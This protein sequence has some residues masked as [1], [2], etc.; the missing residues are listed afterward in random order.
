M[1][2]LISAE[3]WHKRIVERAH[4]DFAEHQL[5]EIG[6]GHWRISRPDDGHYW[7]DIVVM[8]NCAIAVWGDIAGC[9]FAYCSGE[10]TPEGVVAWMANAD[11]SY[12]GRQK[13]H[14]GMGGIG[15]EQYVDGVALYDLDRHLEDAAEGFGVS[16]YMQ[17]VDKPPIGERYTPI[18]EEA[19][20]AIL[21]GDPIEHAHA[22][23][24]DELREFD[25]DCWE[26]VPSIGRVTSVRVIYAL[27]AI[28]RLWELLRVGKTEA[29]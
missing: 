17:D 19:K 23:L 8:R 3:E 7:A 4:E 5:R 15:I 11:V 9:I 26:W 21:R 28:A 27:A 14:I 6:P 2:E 24:A 25:Q 18:I 10:K 13:A 29:A 16:W 1:R 20:E 12:Y 22:R